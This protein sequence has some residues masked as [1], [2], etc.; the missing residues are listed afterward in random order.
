MD[1]IC[2]HSLPARR[3]GSIAAGAE[4][5][6]VVVCLR[7]FGAGFYVPSFDEFA[8]VNVPVL[9]DISVDHTESI[10]RVRRL[11]LYGYT[12]NGQLRASVC[13]TN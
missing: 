2:C 4:C 6:G 11:T 8:H 1:A 3:A 13:E 9:G 7:V 10:G 12:P 5:D